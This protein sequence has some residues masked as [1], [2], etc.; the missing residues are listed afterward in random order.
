MIALDG[1][2][3]LGFNDDYYVDN[4]GAFTVTITTTTV[5]DAGGTITLLGIG[6]GALAYA[7]LRWP[8][9]A[10]NTQKLI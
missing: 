9:A 6:I 8:R 4:R 5:P 1:G 7:R 2:L 3:Y 10:L